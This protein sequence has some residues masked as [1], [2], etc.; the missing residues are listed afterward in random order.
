MDGREV[1]P[2]VCRCDDAWTFFPGEVAIV[3]GRYC[4]LFLLAALTGGAST[5]NA[6]TAAVN[7]VLSVEEMGGTLAIIDA[8]GAVTVRVPIGERPHEVAVSADGKTAYVSQFGIADY[9]NRVGTPGDRVAEIDLAGAHRTAD[10][11]LPPPALGPHGVKLR[12]GTNELFVNAEV[13]GDRMFVFDTQSRKVLRD[14]PLPKGTHNFVFSDDGASLYGFAGEEGISRM[15]AGNGSILASQNPG[16]TIRGLFFTKAGTVLAGGKGEI[17]E[18]RAD[19]L[20]IM[21]R[22]PAP[23][24]GQYLYLEQWPDGTIVAPTLNDDGVAIFPGDGAPARFVATGETPIIVRRGPDDLI[25]VAN[26]EGGHISILSAAG[27]PL[28]TIRVWMGRTASIS[29]SAPAKAGLPSK[30]IRT[31]PSPRRGG[32]HRRKTRSVRPQ[33]RT[34]DGN[35]SSRSGISSIPR[36]GPGG[37]VT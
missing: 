11:V 8:A 26:V 32:S 37:T 23:R 33:K 28:R 18:L 13:G 19:D 5:A 20:S 36:P 27:E 4:L 3:T 1:E 7:C 17:L 22:L 6:E 21:R 16:S 24:P 30:R 35:R 9:D 25:Y 12:P 34:V 2:R 31:L 15:D 14:F 10:F 29:A